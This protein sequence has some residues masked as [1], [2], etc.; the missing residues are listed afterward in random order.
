MAL[1]SI[2]VEVVQKLHKRFDIQGNM[3]MINKALEGSNSDLVVFPEMFI[4]GY[5]IGDEVRNLSLSRD[6]PIFGSLV[7]TAS[8][9]NKHLIFG[10]PERSEKIKGQIFNSA[11]LIGPNGIMGSY[12]KMHLVNF[13]P[14]EE[15]S[16]FTPGNAPFMFEINGYRFGLIICYDIFFPELTKHYA[17][18]G[19]DAVICISA[20]PSVT[21]PFFEAVIKAR[22]IEDTIYFIY[23]NLVGYDSR[24]DFWGGSQVVSPRGSVI[25]KGPYFEESILSATLEEETI[26]LARS[27]RP[28]LRD[29]RF[30]I[31]KALEQI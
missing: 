31:K 15:Y 4:T 5:N 10:Y 9:E 25:S 14:F 20:S 8:A 13:G 17:L 21:R 22:A 29:T 7:D 30:N 27:L 3:K 26:S 24:M 2:K 18:K 6:D 11:M 19:A 1:S 12:R 28:T 23:S 16:Y